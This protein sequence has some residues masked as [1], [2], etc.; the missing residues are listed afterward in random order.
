MQFKTI[1]TALFLGLSFSIHATAANYLDSYTAIKNHLLKGGKMTMIVNNKT[2]CILKSQS[3]PIPFSPNTY[4]VDVRNFVIKAQNGNIEL[5]TSTDFNAPA[6]E[7]NIPP[8]YHNLG[9]VISPQ[10]KILIEETGISLIDYSVAIS[11]LTA[12]DIG[13]EHLTGVKFIAY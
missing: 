3:G 13:N 5:S 4:S 7:K 9:I 12:C 6:P 2:D 10:G 11:F 1:S 8:N